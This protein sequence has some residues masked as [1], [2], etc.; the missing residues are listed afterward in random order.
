MW[1]LRVRVACRSH[2]KLSLRLCA[3]VLVAVAWWALPHP[4]WHRACQGLP[5]L[6]PCNPRSRRPRAGC[7]SHDLWA[8][9]FLPCC[10]HLSP[11]PTTTL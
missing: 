6:L 1:Q 2:Q 7:Q 10:V 4:G 9:G 5:L 3:S 11:T 8:G